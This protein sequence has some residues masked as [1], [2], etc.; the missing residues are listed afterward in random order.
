MSPKK[1]ALYPVQEKLGGAFTDF[2]GWDMPL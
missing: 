2:G 1:T